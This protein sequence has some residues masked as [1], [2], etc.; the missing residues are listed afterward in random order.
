ML[1]LAAPHH[2]DK[3]RVSMLDVDLPA[4]DLLA[5]NLELAPQISLQ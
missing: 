4:L 5:L 1:D 3:V 2:D